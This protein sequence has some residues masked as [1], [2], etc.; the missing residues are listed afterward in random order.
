M[1]HPNNQKLVAHYLGRE[2]SASIKKHLETCEECLARIEAFKHTLSMV[3]EHE[4]P[5]P[6]SNE[7]SDIFV[8]AWAG[9]RRPIREDKPMWWRWG[10]QPA[11][12]FACGLL[13]GFLL[14]GRGVDTEPFLE[15]NRLEVN[16]TNDT[17][18]VSAET[19]TSPV[20]V[21]DA[22]GTPI[23][24]EGSNA[25]FW[26][27]AGL[28]NVKLTPTT[29]YEDGEEVPGALLEGETLNGALVVL[30]F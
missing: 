15:G 28:R 6:E 10:L 12:L 22:M 26:A 18:P 20:L 27:L 13:V 5:L 16:E 23:P 11:G 21:A 29:R 7:S 9:S 2:S 25:D 3:G 19:M 14:F 30:T 4:P 8:T 1:S 17:F 24:E